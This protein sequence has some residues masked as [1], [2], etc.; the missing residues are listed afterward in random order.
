MQVTSSSPSFEEVALRLMETGEPEAVAAFLQTRLD[1]L[2]RDDKAQVCSRAMEQCN[3]VGKL[4]ECLQRVSYPVSQAVCTVGDLEGVV[5]KRGGFV[6]QRLQG[7]S[8][9]SLPP[10]QA[11]MVATWLTELLLD[12]LNR[13]L[14]QPEPGPETS[15][16]G[17]GESERPPG[18]GSAAYSQ[19][20][21][22]VPAQGAG[23]LLM[24]QPVRK[25]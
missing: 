15:N 8:R 17:A 5:L 2:G 3:S 6:W 14:L 18:E 22:E 1:T 19:A 4:G 9:P 21:W 7:H 24:S 13:A 25:G 11:T 16:S 23:S 10:L 12:T 20:S